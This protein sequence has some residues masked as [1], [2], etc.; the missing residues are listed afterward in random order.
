MEDIFD[1][2]IF[3]SHAHSVESDT[4]RYSLDAS[5]YVVLFLSTSCEDIRLVDF[6]RIWAHCGN[7]PAD[8]KLDH[9]CFVITLSFK[10]VDSAKV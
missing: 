1:L 2:T 9:A 4:A 6:H 7:G 8:R 10:E 3:L 5:S